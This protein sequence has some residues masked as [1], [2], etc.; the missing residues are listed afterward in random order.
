MGE[1]FAMYII[2]KVLKAPTKKGLVIS[3]KND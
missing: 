2:D 3:V 1:I